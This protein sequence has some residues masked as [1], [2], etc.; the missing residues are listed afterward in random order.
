MPVRVRHRD[1]F[2]TPD[3]L[4]PRTAAIAGPVTHVWIDGGRH[5]LKGADDAVAEAVAG[6]AAASEDSSGRNVAWRTVPAVPEAELS[7]PGSRCSWYGLC[8][9]RAHRS[10]SEPSYVDDVDRV[11]RV[12]PDRLDHPGRDVEGMAIDPI[13]T[14]AER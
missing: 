14:C 13:G 7:G 3:E 8:P 10:A 12:E 11:P 5:E 4:E 9:L 6:W 2:G 1:P